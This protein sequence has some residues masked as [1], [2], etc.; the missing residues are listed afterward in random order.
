[1]RRRNSSVAELDLVAVTPD[2]RSGPSGCAGWRHGLA[3]ILNGRWGFFLS[4]LLVTAL[5]AAAIGEVAGGALLIVVVAT[6]CAVSAWASAHA[7]SRTQARIERIEWRCALGILAAAWVVF[8]APL[9]AGRDFDAALFQAL[10]FMILALPCAVALSPIPTL[11]AAVANAGRHGVCVTSTAVMEQLATI[12]TVALQTTGVLRRGIPF[13]A[14][15]V[16]LSDAWTEDD[17]LAAAAAVEEHS[18]HHVARAMLGAARAQGVRVVD[19]EAFRAQP[20]FGVQARV[21]G[22]SV[23]VVSPARVLDNAKF[24]ADPGAQ[25]TRAYV[26]V[27][28]SAAQTPVVVVVDGRIIG[29]LALDDELRPEAASAVAALS[30]QLDRAPT[31]LTGDDPHTARALGNAVGIWDVRA[32]LGP[33]D[34]VAATAKLRDSGTVLAVGN[35]SGDAHALGAVCVGVV[36]SRADEPTPET[37]VVVRDGLCAVPALLNLARRA[38]R[39]V[40]ANLALAGGTVTALVI[41]CLVGHLPLLLG[42]AGL[43]GSVVLVGLNSARVLRS[44]WD[45]DSG[46]A[47]DH[48]RSTSSVEVPPTDGPGALT[49]PGS[50]AEHRPV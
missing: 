40:V 32:R 42:A 4:L 26:E 50:N 33:E 30:T 21:A 17:I 41:W 34:K 24:A 8:L 7:P 49:L 43:A 3:A 6:S 35:G 48:S 11:L 39:A 44:R 31:L 23:E 14:A 25:A 29:V 36:V 18:E 5:G 47:P 22:R 27:F 20:G 10:T 16:S 19:A 1:M 15:T 13:L 46:E 38:R 28:G 2:P 45:P 12:D 37:A 9:L